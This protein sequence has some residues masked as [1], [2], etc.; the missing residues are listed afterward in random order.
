[1]AEMNKTSDLYPHRNRHPIS[2]LF[3]CL[4]VQDSLLVLL[5][6]LEQ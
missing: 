3:L 4:I 6:I 2:K 5:E 1:M